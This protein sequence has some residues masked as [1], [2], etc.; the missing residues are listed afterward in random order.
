[1]FEADAR[2]FLWINGLVG[3]VPLLDW[4]MIRLVNDYFIPTT[5]SLVLVALWFW[6]K[7]ATERQN[8][9]KGVFGA[10]IG[11]GFANL[12]VQSINWYYF[13]PRPFTQYEVNLLFYQPSDSS[14]PSNPA[15]VAFAFATGV[16][17]RNRRAGTLMYGLAALFAFSRVYTGVCYPLDV[18]GGAAIGAVVSYVIYWILRLIDPLPTLVI[19]VLRFFYLA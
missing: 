16:W 8:N 9:Q 15:A 19:K 12:A 17:L 1:M 4:L 10:M 2:L 14:F 5:L 11:V 18:I 3:R 6:G 7:E 13:R